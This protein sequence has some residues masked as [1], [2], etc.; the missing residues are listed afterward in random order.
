MLAILA[1][2]V[3][4]AA[5]ALG[6][7][8][9]RARRPGPPAV[10]SSVPPAVPTPVVLSVVVPPPA[11]TPSITRPDEPS[12]ETGRAIA[13][14]TRIIRSY[15]AEATLLRGHL[16]TGDAEI[17]QLRSF[18]ADRRQQ[19]VDLAQARADTARYRQIVVDLE[20][21]AP[22]LL[23]GPGA[24]D[25]LKLIVGVGPVLERMLHQLGVGTYRQIA[26]WSERDIDDFDAKLPEF[27]GRIRRDG[28]VTQA[29]ALHQAKFGE[30]LPSRGS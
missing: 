14:R 7:V 20:N 10:P 4:S 18:A 8:F 9:G 11:V 22:S 16:V 29:R 27:P 24:P 28:W 2:V 5:F 25:D 6:Y 15:E 1:I 19:F 30:I 26:H 3:V 13:E 12:P 21:N 23:F 17:A